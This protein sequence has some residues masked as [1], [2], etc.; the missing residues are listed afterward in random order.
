MTKVKH[1][2]KSTTGQRS[3]SWFGQRAHR[4]PV[5]AVPMAY[6]M[7]CIEVVLEESERAASVYKDLVSAYDRP[8]LQTLDNQIISAISDEKN[9]ELK[10]ELVS[11]ASEA[12]LN[13][14]K[15]WSDLMELATDTDAW[16][17]LF[18]GPEEDGDT[19][20]LRTEEHAGISDLA[21]LMGL[22]L[23]FI[24]VGFNRESDLA[25]GKC[26]VFPSIEAPCLLLGV[27]NRS[28]WEHYGLSMEKLSNKYK[29]VQV[30]RKVYDLED[31][32]ANH[33]TSRVHREIVAA[34]QSENLLLRH[35]EKF[36]KAARLWY[37]CRVAHS[38]IPEYLSAEAVKPSAPLEPPDIKNLQKQVRPC[39]D[40]VGYQR[41]TFRQLVD[42]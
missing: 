40:A 29:A 22:V 14:H 12:M 24:V 1:S 21:Y 33:P 35:D 41:R 28:G 2:S 9:K 17:G 16:D 15:P 8:G 37:Q 25:E 38:G 32:M 11:A 19:D 23:K 7:A 31:V 42:G 10:R 18:E 27:L 39:D 20:S 4:W 30:G 26:K 5:E 36:L 34:A 3:G 6:A 13:V